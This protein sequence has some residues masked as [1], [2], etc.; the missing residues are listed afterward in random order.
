MSCD[1]LVIFVANSTVGGLRLALGHCP[2]FMPTERMNG[3]GTTEEENF[4]CMFC[5]F[6]LSMFHSTCRRGI[7]WSVTEQSSGHLLCFYFE[8]PGV[9]SSLQV[10]NWK[11]RKKPLPHQLSPQE[12]EI[13]HIA[14]ELLLSPPISLF[15]IFI[16]VS[17]CP[18]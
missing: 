7:C 11:T 16:S 2:V 14:Q 6:S 15:L 13:N 17:P 12:E 5:F 9:R 4:H 10:D 8:G 18:L 3:N 1:L